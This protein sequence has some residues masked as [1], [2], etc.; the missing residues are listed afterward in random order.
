MIAQ[1]TKRKT[2]EELNQESI[3]FSESNR[4]LLP[5]T[6]RA[7]PRALKEDRHQSQIYLKIFEK[8]FDNYFVFIKFE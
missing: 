2:I 7:C 5:L 6:Q 3:R 4:L 1:R 8:E